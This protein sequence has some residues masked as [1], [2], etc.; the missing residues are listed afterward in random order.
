MKCKNICLVFVV[1]SSAVFSS[2]SLYAQ[3]EKT[4]EAPVKKVLT[5]M[6]RAKIL[7]N[8]IRLKSVFF[9]NVEPLQ[10]V[11]YLN[12]RIKRTGYHLVLD[13]TVQESRSRSIYFSAEQITAYD[14]IRLLCAVG[15]MQA[16]FSGNE[17]KLSARNTDELDLSPVSD[18]KVMQRLQEITIDTAKFTGTMPEFCQYLEATVKKLDAD[19]PTINFI[20]LLNR[21]IRFNIY[22]RNVNILDLINTVCEA[23]G[24]AYFVEPFGLVFVEEDQ[25]VQKISRFAAT[26]MTLRDRL[27]TQKMPEA[28]KFTETPLVDIIMMVGKQAKKVQPDMPNL[29]IKVTIP[30]EEL[31]FYAVSGEVPEGLTFMEFLKYACN[32]SGADM[33]IFGDTLVIASDRK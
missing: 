23:K 9:D 33:R 26:T 19:V 21:S 15:K 13:L 10:A 25:G 32:A 3:T 5:Q 29:N 11:E 17:I 30:K 14:T 24:M 20:N 4:S 6:E 1:L 18:L 12:T 16:S 8:R 2:F 28:V 22:Q 31:E 7:L 27:E